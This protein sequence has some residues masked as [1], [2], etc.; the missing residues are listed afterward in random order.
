MPIAQTR[1]L[2]GR[3]QAFAGV[4]A[5]RLQHAIPAIVEVRDD[6]RL[7]DKTHQQIE[8]LRLLDLAA[9]ADLLG[10]VERPAAREHGQATEQHTL[11]RRKQ[12]VAPVDQCPQRLLPRQRR[13]ATPRQQVEAI[14]KAGGDRIQRHRAHAGS[15]K[16]DRERYAVEMPADLRNRGCIRIGDPERW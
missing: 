15:G 4:L 16:L 14:L 11:R 2:A 12:V 9:G 5:D 13:P 10:C 3:L 7:V 8:N 6:E 1:V